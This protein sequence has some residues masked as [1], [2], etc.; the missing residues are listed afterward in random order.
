MINGKDEQEGHRRSMDAE[1]EELQQATQRFIR[2]MFRT[3]VSVALLP[4]NR[5]PPKPRQHFHAAGREFTHGLATLVHEL[6][7]GLEKMVKDTN[8]ST[9]L[10]DGPHPDGESD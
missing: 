6:A 4:V 3:G 7:D 8:P 2:S 9:T 10:G 1:R 5:L